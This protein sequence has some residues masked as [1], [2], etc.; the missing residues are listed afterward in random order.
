MKETSEGGGAIGTSG[1]GGSVDV[2]GHEGG[3]VNVKV[4]VDR[5]ER[6]GRSDMPKTLNN[7]HVSS[8]R[9]V[10]VASHA[11]SLYGGVDSSHS[12][13]VAS[14]ADSHYGGVD[15]SHDVL[16]SLKR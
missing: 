5:I 4:E 6:R 7:F 16:V 10:E 14:H 3:H 1:I 15:S 9:S 11:D 8:S 13:G 2:L 12:V